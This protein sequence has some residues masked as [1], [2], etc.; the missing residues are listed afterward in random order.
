MRWMVLWLRRAV[1]VLGAVMMIPGHVLH[2][3]EEHK[4]A[5]FEPVDG[6]INADT[7][8]EEWTFDG[9]ANQVV[10]V[11][12]MTTSGDLDPIVDLIAPDGSTAATNDDLDSLVRDAGFEAVALPATGTYIVRVTR[13]GTTTGRYQLILTPGYARLARQESFEGQESPWV[14]LE[15]VATSL[16]DNRLRLLIGV[17]NTAAIAIPSD[18]EAVDD[19]YMQVDARLFGNPSYAE[20]G[21][22]FRY[23]PSLNGSQS[24]QF[25]INSLGQ[26]TVLYLDGT[27]QFALRSWSE[28]SLLSGATQW[29][30]AVLARGNTLSFFANDELLG[31]VTD[32]RLLTAGT[33]GLVAGTG[34]NQADDVTVLF[35]NFVLTTR[36]GSTYQGLPLTLASWDSTDPAAI[37]AELAESGQ[38][39]PVEIHD[40]YIPAKTLSTLDLTSMSELLGSEK[41]VYTDFVLGGTINIATTGE[42]V[43]C[44]LA[45][46]W[47]D[48]RN[49]SLAFVD[50]SGGWG[51]VRAV[52][53]ELTQNVYD[54]SPQVAAAG[55]TSTLVLVVHGEDVALYING[56]LVTQE[57]IAPVEG[58]VG[59]MLLN[60]EDVGT[61]CYFGGIWVWPLVAE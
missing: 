57:Q 37:T 48:E 23:Q 22:V 53:A 15:N 30:L 21:F 20:L 58:R 45:F 18:A 16:I 3:Q 46:G 9:R 32:D 8:S 2:A 5:W 28:N 38:I 42:S 61:D 35:D 19:F 52:D 39:T 56:A 47:Q 13:Y 41:A 14:T 6:A 1:I 11:I 34:E 29:T 50:T 25:R 27:G 33:A 36:L 60:Y 4:L 49:L 10:S 17:P 51:I 54:H 59:V 44:G 12:V 40:L 31:T 43:G 26:W 7:L 55:E 24:Y